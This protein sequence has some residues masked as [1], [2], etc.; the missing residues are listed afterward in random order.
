M[1][2]TN[3]FPKLIKELSYLNSH[4]LKVGIPEKTGVQKNGGA[5]V[6]EYATYNEYG[7]KHIP[8]RPFVS[9]TT[10]EKEG[11]KREQD[12]VVLSIYKQ[13]YSAQQAMQRLGKLAQGDIRR[14]VRAIKTPANAPS[15]VAKKGRNNPLI[16]TGTMARAINYDI[17]R[18]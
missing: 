17:E 18:G 14:T 10:D 4:S 15:T 2:D 3:H 1:Q 8:A 16:E 13:K 7:T 6:A 9:K 5:T 12:A 11:W